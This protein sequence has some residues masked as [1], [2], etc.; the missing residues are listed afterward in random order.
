MLGERFHN[1]L[2]TVDE[3]IIILKNNGRGR[4]IDLIERRNEKIAYRYYYYAYLQRQQNWERILGILANEFDL[5]D[6]TLSR[7]ITTI[8]SENIRL[9]FNEKP[10][11]VDLKKKFP[12]FNW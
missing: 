11:V 7:I 1:S 4:N 9:L 5:S 8:L 12:Y 10:T 3:P 2:F 6:A